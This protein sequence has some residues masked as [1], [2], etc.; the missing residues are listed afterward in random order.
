MA[1]REELVALISNPESFLDDE[2]PIHRRMAITAL[3]AAGANS[4][5]DTLVLMLN[6]EEAA[7]RAA[8]AEKRRDQPRRADPHVAVR[9]C[10]WFP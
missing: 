2:D 4:L 1:D 3:D 5:F 6:D 7:I 8:A 9:D 10:L